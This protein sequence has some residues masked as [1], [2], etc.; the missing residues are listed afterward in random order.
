LS[1]ESSSAVALAAA[2]NWLIAFKSCLLLAISCWSN[3]AIAATL[4]RFTLLTNADRRQV[5]WAGVYTWAALQHEHQQQQLKSYFL[6][7][8]T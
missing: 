1:A 7:M 6:L 5:S 2:A 3:P 4:A 8:S